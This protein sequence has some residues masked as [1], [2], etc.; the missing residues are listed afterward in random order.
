MNR[1]SFLGACLALGVAPAIVRADSLMRVVPHDLVIVAP[2][3]EWTTAITRPA[4][5]GGAPMWL[6]AY[7]GDGELWVPAVVTAG[8]LVNK[9]AEL[10]VDEYRR[11]F[12]VRDKRVAGY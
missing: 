1:R 2:P 11:S 4:L 10:E 9:R 12:F 6:R 7:W 5:V 8:E 3:R